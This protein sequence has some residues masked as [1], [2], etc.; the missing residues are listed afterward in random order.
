MRLLLA[1]LLTLTA[2][3]PVAA[4][5]EKKDSPL[6]AHLPL[7][8]EAC[9]GRVYDAKHLASRPK[10]QVTAFHLSREFKPDP[11]SENEPATEEETKGYDGQY[12]HVN[13]TA[14]I[15]FR[16]R[17]GVY[18]NT[19]N[20]GKTG[21][22]KV[23][24]G[25]D[26][27][28]GSFN[29][30]PAGDALLLEN[31]GFVVVGGCGASE[32]EREN[33]AYVSPATDDKLFRLE[34]KPFAACTAEREAMAPVWAKLGTPLRTRFKDHETLCLS[35][36][37]DAAHL[38]SHPQQTVKRIAVLKTRESKT[39]PADTVYKLTFRI[40]TKDGKKFEKD[41]TC[42]PD[43]YAFGCTI[44]MEMDTQRDFYLTRA[45]DNDVMLR[46][47]HGL[48]AKLFD[49]KLGTDDRI[50]RLRPAPE[51]ACRF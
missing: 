4:E 12:G 47:R 25:V 10:Q 29:L 28:G 7:R 34:R 17:K 1:V 42:A 43:N 32:D 2:I 22:G 24:C 41:T 51:A 37:Y 36:S 35:R 9:F 33:E 39:D 3:A 6:P 50:F 20:C 21:D 16:D 11:F 49:A 48:L 8:T 30:R 31:N 45:A 26:C 14:Y 18:A 13:V 40:E 38:K 46:D 15:R 23:V 5:S 44:N 19:L 27:D